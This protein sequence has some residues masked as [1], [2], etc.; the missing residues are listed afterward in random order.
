MRGVLL[1]PLLSIRGYSPRTYGDDDLEKKRDLTQLL[2]KQ[3]VDPQL[4]IERCR[5]KLLSLEVIFRIFEDN[6]K[7]SAK[8][9]DNMLKILCDTL[10]EYV[11]QS[12]TTEGLGLIEGKSDHVIHEI[13]CV[14]ELVP[15]EEEEGID[16]EIF[17]WE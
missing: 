15:D 2:L 17:E 9:L 8:D 6:E 4:A 16:L 3:I 1:L 7:G 5:G 11:D 10:P 12:R 13:H 14:K